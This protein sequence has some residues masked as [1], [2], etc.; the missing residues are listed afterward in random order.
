VAEEPRALA[1]ETVVGLTEAEVIDLIEGW[2]RAE[3]DLLYGKA[4]SQG[5]ALN[6][7]VTRRLFAEARR[8]MGLTSRIA[9]RPD[10]R[11]AS[12]AEDAKPEDPA[13][14]LPP[15]VAAPVRPKAERRGRFSR[16]RRPIN[17]AGLSNLAETLEAIVA[18]RDRAR[19]AIEEI[20]RIVKG[21]R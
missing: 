18:E 6:L 11:R 1:P 8:R 5:R 20:A 16:R 14:A 21:L 7:E 13:A 15:A 3:P 4:R 10:R 17:L 12:K 19:A 2:V 9:P